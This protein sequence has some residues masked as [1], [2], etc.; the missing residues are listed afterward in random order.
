M[1]RLRIARCPGEDCLQRVTCIRFRARNLD[2]SQPPIDPN[3]RTDEGKGCA[4]Y[5]M[6]V[7]DVPLHPW[8]EQRKADRQ[9]RFA[10]HNPSPCA[11][12]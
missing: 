12:T 7:P 1:K 3:I 2:D 5:M 6:L 11:P 10:P 4:M 9:T 8:K